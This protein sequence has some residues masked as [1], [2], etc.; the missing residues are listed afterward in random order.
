VGL[1]PAIYIFGKTPVEVVNKAR[2]IARELRNL[3]HQ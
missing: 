2:R 3:K 1:E